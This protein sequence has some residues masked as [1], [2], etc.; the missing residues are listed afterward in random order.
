[1]TDHTVAYQTATIV[2][3][4]VIGWIA[5]LAHG[6]YVTKVDAFRKF[7]DDADSLLN[8]KDP[9]TTASLKALVDDAKLIA[10]K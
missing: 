8:G 5:K 3:P 6:N 1:M 10:N 7:V 9:V 4:F 2:I